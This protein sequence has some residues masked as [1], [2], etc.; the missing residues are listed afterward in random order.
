MLFEVDEAVNRIRQE[1]APD[2]NILFGSALTEAM[3]GRV[4]VSVVATGIDAEDFAR[5]IPDNVQPLRSY[6][7]KAVMVEI[8][9]APVGAAAQPRSDAI[10][11]IHQQVEALAQGLNQQPDDLQ[12]TIREAHE[13]ALRADP[14][15]LGGVE[16]PMIAEKD[17]PVP[18]GPTLREGAGKGRTGVPRERRGFAGLF[19]RGKRESGGT[20]PRPA[21]AAPGR[22]GA[23]A[24]TIGAR[25]SPAQPSQQAS[26]VVVTTGMNIAG[27]AAVP[28]A[29]KAAP[30]G[31]KGSGGDLFGGQNEDRRSAIP[32]F[33]RNQDKPAEAADERFEI[34]AFLRRQA[35]SGS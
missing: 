11:P 3:E 28:A 9:L 34:P 12:Q 2:A 16:A 5:A 14:V 20:A 19:G 1:V 26:K 13:A 8:P 33:L 30:D 27:D 15:L 23:V 6:R 35:S 25:L 7:N 24:Q 17:G 10:N 32:A 22:Q 18:P 21:M 31:A 29:T 4:R